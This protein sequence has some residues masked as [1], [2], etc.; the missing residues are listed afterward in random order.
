MQNNWRRDG[1]GMLELV[2]ACLD[3]GDTFFQHLHPRPPTVRILAII[4]SITAGAL[5]AN[6][7]YP[8]AALKIGSENGS[9]RKQFMDLPF[10]DVGSA[11]MPGLS[12]D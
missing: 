11:Y 6:W 10:F 3:F 2:D 9:S 12:G 4:D 7:P 5:A 1:V 8:V